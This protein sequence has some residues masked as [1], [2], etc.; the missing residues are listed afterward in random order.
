VVNCQ[1]VGT[2]ANSIKY[3]APYVFKVAISNKRIVKLENGQVFFKY[4]KSGSNRWRTMALQVIEFIRRFL[5]HVLPS[6]FM[7]VRYYGFMNPA[8]SIAMGKIAKCIAQTLAVAKPAKAEPLGRIWPKC[9]D[10]G[11]RLI[12]C[13]SIVP[14]DLPASGTR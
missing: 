9:S 13:A 11:G 10:C 6:G 4:K 2:G 12:Y 3:L 14:F 7:K 8:S 1:A 5:Q